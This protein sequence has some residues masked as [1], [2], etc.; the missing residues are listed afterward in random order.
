MNYF[1]AQL[2][3]ICNTKFEFSKWINDKCYYFNNHKVQLFDEAQTICFEKFEE[4]GF[5]NG[6]LFEP[7]DTDIFFKIY[8]LVEKFSKKP[9]LQ[10]W[11]SISV[12]NFRSC[13]IQHVS[14]DLSQAEN[15]I[16]VV[17]S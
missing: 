9:T 16:T 8:K 11:S 2:K 12:L 1:L 4:Y 10:L 14:R 7:E 6:K 5:N 15:N 17:T 3:E 13:P